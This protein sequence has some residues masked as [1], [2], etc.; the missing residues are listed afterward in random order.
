MY[1]YGR[2]DDGEEM[3][4]YGRTDGGDQFTLVLAATCSYCSMPMPVIIENK[5]NVEIGIKILD[6]GACQK[7]RALRSKHAEKDVQADPVDTGSRGA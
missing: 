2:T 5:T 7:L 1:F 3:N 4:L 6:C